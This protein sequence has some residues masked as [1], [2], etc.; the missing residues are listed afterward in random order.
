MVRI[1]RRRLLGRL[2]RLSLGA[3]GQ[4]GGSRGT[5]ARSARGVAQ[6]GCSIPWTGEVRAPGSPARVRVVTRGGVRSGDPRQVC[7]REDG[8]RSFGDLEA[9]IMDRI[10][11][12]G[13]PMLVR[14]VQQA[15]T[16]ERAYNTVLTVVDILYRKGWL[17]RE[18]DGR[19]YRYRAVVTREDYTA[20]LMREVL[21]ASSDRAA[22]LRRFAERIAPDEA[23]QLRDAL[24]Q[25]QQ[26][27]ERR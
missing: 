15:L 21:A 1:T 6:P 9:A 7:D 3:E 20:G 4:A 24:E 17:V 23:E 14:D 26:A 18:K 16:P 8:V 5:A 12:A 22:T 10:W 27:G 2:P 19:A 25:A 11:S 13:R